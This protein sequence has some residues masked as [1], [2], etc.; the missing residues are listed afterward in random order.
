M[1][2]E[3]AFTCQC[4]SELVEHQDAT[5]EFDALLQCT[6][7]ESRYVVTLTRMPAPRTGS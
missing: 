4:G 7:C 3:F 5:R 1:T 6:D 2:V